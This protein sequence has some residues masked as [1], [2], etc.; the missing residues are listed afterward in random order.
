MEWILEKRRENRLDVLKAEL[1]ENAKREEEIRL[2]L[3]A[4][5]T[6]LKTIRTAG[7]LGLLMNLNVKKL[8]C[9]Q[10]FFSL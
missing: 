10:R 2:R 3:E 8:L 6:Q 9:R 5:E 4:L 1:E 7:K